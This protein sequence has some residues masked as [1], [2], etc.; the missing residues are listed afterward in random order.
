MALYQVLLHLDIH[1]KYCCLFVDVKEEVEPYAFEE[2]T[3][4]QRQNQPTTVETEVQVWLLCCLR[5]NFFLQA[6]PANNDTDTNNDIG[7]DLFTDDDF[8]PQQHDFEQT[9]PRKRARNDI[10]T[11]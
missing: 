4:P 8:L 11:I 10:G 9:L 7:A 1:G 5:D 2:H 6:S 3:V